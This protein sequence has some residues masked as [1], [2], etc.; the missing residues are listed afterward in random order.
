[1]RERKKSRWYALFLLWCGALG[2]ALGGCAELQRAQQIYEVATTAMVPANVVIPAANAFDILKATATN[3]GSYCIAQK[4]APSICAAAT[5]RIVVKFVR[6]GTAARV[7]MESSLATG[8][9]VPSSVYNILIA[10]V[11]ALN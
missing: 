6:S 10:A 3:Y 1:M 11:Q 9:P 4:M 5:R 2:M 8:Q 7:Q